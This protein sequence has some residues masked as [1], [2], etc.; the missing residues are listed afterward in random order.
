MVTLVAN[1][2]DRIDVGEHRLGTAPGRY[3]LIAFGWINVALGVVGMFLPLL[4]TTVFLLIALWAFAKSSQRFH[5]WLYHHP[6]LGPPL[7]AWH[8]HGA[9]ATPAK[10]LAVSVMALSVTYTAVFVDANW[11]LPAT[12]AAVMIPIATWIITRPNTANLAAVP[13]E[14]SE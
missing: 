9:I 10:V 5:D 3:A 13:A 14:D 12:I 1:S 11:T 6:R 2:E 7:R 8:Q 4:P